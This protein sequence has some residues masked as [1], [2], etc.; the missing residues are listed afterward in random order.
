MRMPKQPQGVPTPYLVHVHP[1]PTRFHGSIYTR[2]EFGLPAVVEVQNTIKPSDMDPSMRLSYSATNQYQGAMQG[3][4]CGCGGVGQSPDGMGT[5]YNTESG[6]YRR[7]E[8][9]GGGIFN[10]AIGEASGGGS[11]VTYLAYAAAFA[12]GFGVIYYATRK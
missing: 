12:A 2:P 1:Y 4:D 6:V 11:M 10:N 7:P 3:S 9:D 5:L 8:S